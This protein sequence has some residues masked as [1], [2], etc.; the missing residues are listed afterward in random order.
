MECDKLGIRA[1]GLSDLRCL[2]ATVSRVLFMGMK[3]TLSDE[4][5]AMKC[6]EKNFTFLLLLSWVRYDLI[7]F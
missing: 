4:R 2:K 1:L 6:F 7:P 3:C 5:E